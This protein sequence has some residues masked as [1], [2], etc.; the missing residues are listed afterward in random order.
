MTST[1]TVPGFTAAKTCCACGKPL[2]DI[3]E[4]QYD[5]AQS[6][7]V[8][9]YYLYYVIGHAVVNTGA[10]MFLYYTDL[11]LIWDVENWWPYG[12]QTMTLKG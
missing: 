7:E 2:D 10:A 11:R 3:T 9:L 6:E 4:S 1:T 5:R 12:D 8:G